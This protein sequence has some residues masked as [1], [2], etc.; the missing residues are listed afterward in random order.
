MQCM[1]DM[2]TQPIQ[3]HG[4]LS[5]GVAGR[6]TKTLTMQVC[7][8]GWEPRCCSYLPPCEAYCW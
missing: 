2:P 5:A 1:L 8:M 6:L 7:A 4:E 3:M